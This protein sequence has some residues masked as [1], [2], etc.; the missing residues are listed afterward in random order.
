MAVSDTGRVALVTG[1]GRGIGKAIALA[2][3]RSDYQVALVARTIDEIDATANEITVAGGRA[4]AIRAD[5]RDAGAVQRAVAT[6]KNR[7][8]QVTPSR[9]QCRVCR[10]GKTLWTTSPLA[11]SE[12]L[13]YIVGPAFDGGIAYLLS[14]GYLNALNERTGQPIWSQEATGMFIAAGQGR[15]AVLSQEQVTVWDNAGRR[16]WSAPVPPSKWKQYGATFHEGR[17]FVFV[18]GEYADACGD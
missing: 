9:Q 12:M 14:Y 8:G 5:V 4:Q 18:P 6:T 7:L 13:F 1:A 2:L 16:L 17:L 11:S 10:T 15:V 3:A